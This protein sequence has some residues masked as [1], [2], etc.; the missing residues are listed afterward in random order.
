MDN[1][2]DVSMNDQIDISINDLIDVYFIY[3]V[4]DNPKYDDLFLPKIQKVFKQNL[5]NFLNDFIY[6]VS[7]D[8]FNTLYKRYFNNESD[9]YKSFLITSAIKNIN[10][11][12]NQKYIR[13]AF[14]PILKKKVCINDN[15]TIIYDIYNIAYTSVYNY[16][17][18]YLQS[19]IYLDDN[20]RKIYS[21]IIHL[22][23]KLLDSFNDQFIMDYFN[24]HIAAK[25]LLINIYGEDPK[26]IQADLKEN[27]LLS[28]NVLKTYDYLADAIAGLNQYIEFEYRIMPTNIHYTNLFYTNNNNNIGII[29]SAR[30]FDQLI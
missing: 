21:K 22:T 14:Y 20:K 11:L 23:N 5:I 12:S 30:N 15:T 27:K 8:N 19:Y 6:Y 2:I 16:F 17:Y 1:Q 18:E 9:Q 26:K 28:Y 3:D 13:E 4:S 25:Y 29:L 10:K 24:I 7:Y